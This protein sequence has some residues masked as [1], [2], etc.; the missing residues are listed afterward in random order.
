MINDPAA[1]VLL[2]D[3]EIATARPLGPADADAVRT[4]HERLNERDR[5]FRFFGSAPR[6]LDALARRIATGPDDRRA[7]VGCFLHDELIGVAHF[8]RFPESDDAEIAMV[9]AAGARHRGVATLLVEHLVS[10]ARQ[11][12]VRRFVAE[13][14]AENDAVTSVLTQLG[15]PWQGRIGGPEREFTVSLDETDGYLAAVAGREAGADVASLRHLFQP[16]SVVVVGAGRAPTSVGHAVLANLVDSGFSGVLRAVNPHAD[17]VLGV[18]CFPS[19]GALDRDVELAVLCLRAD[20]CADALDECGRRG[21]RA[22]VVV[23]AGLTGRPAGRRLVEVARR[24]GIRL[25]GPNCLGVAVTA[26]GD[27]MNA[28]FL[29]GAVPA[30]RIG[31]VTQSGGVGIALAEALRELGLGMSTLV[32]TGDKYDVSG[33]DLLLWWAADTETDIAVLYLESFGNPRKFSRFARSLARTKPVVAVRSGAS[34]AAAAAAQSHTA[35]AATPAV[36]RDALYRQ[37]GVIAVDSVAGLVAVVAALSWQP[38]PAGT[39][40]AVVSNAGGAGVLA[41]DAADRLGLTVATLSDA[42]AERLAGLLPPGA[43]T[44]NPVDTTAAVPATAF[45]EALRAVAGDDGVDAVIAVTVPTAVG[46]PG[47]ALPEAIRRSAA[48]VLA[49][50]PGQLARVAPLGDPDGEIVAPCYDDPESAAAVLAALGP[51]GEWLG[52]SAVAAPRPLDIE[53]RAVRTLLSR[54]GEGWLSP[55]EL[56]EFA[57]HAGLP[58]VGT[59]YVR[60]DEAAVAEF[61]RLGGGPVVLKADAAG[62]LHKNAA[63]GV[64]TGLAD[65]AA[66]REGMRTLRARFGRSLRGVVLQRQARSGRELLI[67]VRSDPEF[68]PLLVFGLGGVDTDLIA[69]H[70][71]RL[72][73]LTERDAD[74]MLDGLRCS[75]ALWACPRQRAAVR[76]L[77]LRVSSLAEWF[78]ELA[79]LDLN[80]IRVDGDR[81]QVLDIRARVGRATAHDPVLRRLRL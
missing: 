48:P 42:T 36:T 30:G 17:S 11:A 52:E 72:A 18:P 58:L 79:E 37:A 5:Y 25:V 40:V 66:L 54:A 55:P 56:V 63:G 76:D 67:G 47:E 26:P 1:R 28:T 16:A 69:D 15:L 59:R 81:C 61:G 60:D 70:V 34:A 71:A 50:R 7:A 27:G 35:A 12:G 22:A 3:G 2:A 9:V 23:S 6:G 19:V 74:R 49:V 78:P 46:D 68:G 62:V 44:V 77:L 14:L 43:T 10:L 24:H 8:E 20:Q 13:T 51:Y 41:A 53:S 31:V 21:V 75:A 45:G 39:R 57:G 4:L 33:N 32:S 38:V 73:P 80:P 65:A 29:R 64:L